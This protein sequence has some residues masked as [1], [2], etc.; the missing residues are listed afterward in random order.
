[1]T[2][3]EAYVEQLRK[4][5]IKIWELETEMQYRE[6]G[7]GYILDAAQSLVYH[8]CDGCNQTFNCDSIEVC[9]RTKKLN[10]ILGKYK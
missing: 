3:T 7:Y 6:I 5:Q 2:S 9:K 1:M 8:L 4:L 10:D